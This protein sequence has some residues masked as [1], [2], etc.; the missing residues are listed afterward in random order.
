MMKRLLAIRWQTFLLLFFLCLLCGGCHRAPQIADG[1]QEEHEYDQLLQQKQWA[2]IVEKNR[3]T[4]T[5]SEACYNVV[6]LA[7]WH[8]GK[9]SRVELDKCLDDS[10]GVL[11]SETSAL[12]M[13]D[14][15]LQLGMVNMARRAAFDAMVAMRNERPNSRALKRLTEVAII[16]HEY[17]LAMK[18]IKIGEQYD[19]CRP[20]AKRLR[21]LVEHPEKIAE[22]PSY[23]K[24]REIHDSKK[25]EFFL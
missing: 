4:P 15:Y 18:Y 6:R 23:Q 9:C 12:M 3:L 16:T 10:H 2:K 13:S 7:S 24:L 22:F 1:T 8:L 11:G 20:W 5:E 21:P 19:D 17:D 25:D 14:I